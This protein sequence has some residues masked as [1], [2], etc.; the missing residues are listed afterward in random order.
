ASR[1][2]EGNLNI[3]AGD[4]LTASTPTTVSQFYAGVFKNESICG[5]NAAAGQ[6]DC[7]QVGAVYGFSSSDGATFDAQNYQVPGENTGDL[8]GTVPGPWA[9]PID[10][11]QATGPNKLKYAA[12]LPSQ[13]APADGYPVVIFG[14]GLT[15]SRA[16]LATLSIQLAER[17]LA[18]I[19]IDWPASGSRAVQKF[20]TSACQD[21]TRDTATPPDPTVSVA[22]YEPILTVNLATTRDNVRQGVIDV[23]REIEVLKACSADPTVCGGFN[24]NAEKIAYV[25]QSLGSLIGSMD[26]AMSPDI[27]AAVLNVAGTSWTDIL[28]NSDSN[29]VKCP[30]IDALI[31]SGTITG[32]L[33]QQPDG[34]LNNVDALCVNT[35]TTQEYAPVAL[36][37]YQAFA[38]AARWIL[39]PAD[40]VNFLD[41]VNARVAAGSLAVL[42]QRVEGDLVIPNESTDILATFLGLTTETANAPPALGAPITASASA[43]EAT[44]RKALL[45]YVSGDVTTYTH[46]SLL[47]PV[48]D[49]VTGEFTPEG[50]TGTGQMQTDA[51]TFLLTHL[52]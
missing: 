28:E 13:A 33:W 31:N 10:P 48:T 18:S 8:S 25:G 37:A 26:I 15:R 40:S 20:P 7:S 30:I 24:V 44:K 36:P 41:R 6:L 11:P 19:A 3:A 35:D 51:I 50:R 9:D 12:F 34:T 14:H 32:K 4:P 43:A 2:D 22:C 5:T 17:G 29:S 21:P 23:L 27:K 1:V 39:D 47:S 52:Q 49:P 45:N 46:G 42:V 16:D 38:A